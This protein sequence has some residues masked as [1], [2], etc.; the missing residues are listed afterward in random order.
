MDP[1]VKVNVGLG[2]NDGTGDPLRDAFI[3]LNKNVDTIA[4]AIGAAGGLATLGAD[5]RLPSGQAPIDYAAVLP[6]TAH[7]LNTYVTP[8]TFY[9]AALAG[10]TAPTGVNYPVAQ[11]GFLEVVATGTPVLQVYTTRN[12]TP[13]I[14]QRFWR[15]RV[16]T[17]TWSAWKEIADTTTA[18]TYQGAMPA[19]QDLN[20]YTQRGAWIVASSATATGGTNFPI[21]QSGVL[22]VYSA[23][24]PGGTA[25]TG[26]N[27]VYIAS[28]SNRQY[29]RSLVG[30]TWSAWEE[31]VRSSLIGATSG[32]GSLGTDGRQPVGQAPYSAV[33]PAGTDANTLATP[34]VWHNNSDAQATVALNW[35]QQLAGTLNVE[36]VASGNM[37]VTQTYTTRNGTGGVFRTYKRV[38]FG[39]AGTWGTW[40]EV[41]RLADAESLAEAARSAGR[42]VFHRGPGNG[43][44]TTTVPQFYID[45]CAGGGGGGGGAGFVGDTFRLQGAGGGA[46]ESMLGEIVTA[47]VGTLVTWTVGTGGAGGAGGTV[48][49]AGVKGVDGTNTVITV[50]T[51]PV[52]TFTLTRGLGGLPGAS[53][54]PALGGTG[55][56][57]GGAGYAGSVPAAATYPQSG[58][59]GSSAFGGGGPGVASLSGPVNGIP[60]A[61]YG[62]GGGGGACPATAGNAGGRGGDGR[63]GFLKIYW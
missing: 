12:A 8:G 19:A 53:G 46:G 35:P 45:G 31:V 57:T 36:A 10:A 63:G 47:P 62:S 5:G 54:G 13:A 60:G 39:A 15:V 32:V 34:G 21:G 25:A 3:K 20:T 41:A 28:N 17:A 37:Q 16:S 1:L 61:G 49:N 18:W 6:T 56:P 33:L 58:G 14:M 4:G 44:W 26:A 43:S 9:Q 27:Q 38:R 29:F 48:N 40:Q 23:G 11:V 52:Q 30:G 7:D 55:Y 51:S 2:P 42:A 24:Y 59:G 22:L 50:Q